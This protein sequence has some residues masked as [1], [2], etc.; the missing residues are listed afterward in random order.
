MHES[1][2]EKLSEFSREMR[3]PRAQ[4]GGAFWKGHLVW[5]HKH[6]LSITPQN[7]KIMDLTYKLIRYFL[8]TRTSAV[9]LP[10]EL[11]QLNEA[12]IP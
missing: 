3:W 5:R 10:T 12:S 2:G 9:L 6:T 1:V 11:Y 7:A 4:N 8:F